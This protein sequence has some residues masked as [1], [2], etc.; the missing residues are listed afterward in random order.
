MFSSFQAMRSER[1]KQYWSGDRKKEE[2]YAEAPR[3]DAY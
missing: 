2:L 1:I 3:V